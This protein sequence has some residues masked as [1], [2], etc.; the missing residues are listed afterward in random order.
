MS[1]MLTNVTSG[2][3]EK[4]ANVATTLCCPSDLKWRGFPKELMRLIW[5]YVGVRTDVVCLFEN[6]CRETSRAVE[7]DSQLLSLTKHGVI[8]RKFE[9]YW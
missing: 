8:V 7:N 2:E 9:D 5:G 3:D 6:L 1:K 4:Q